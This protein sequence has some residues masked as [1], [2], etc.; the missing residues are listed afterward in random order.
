[1]K[2]VTGETA[3]TTKGFRRPACGN[4]VDCCGRAAVPWSAP[5]CLENVGKAGSA[6]QGRVRVHGV[7]S[8]VTTV[9]YVVTLYNKRRFLPHLLAGLS[10]QEGAFGRQIIFVDDGSTDGTVELLKELTAGWEN[11]V[12]LHQENAGPAA[13]TNAGIAVAGGQFIKPVDGDDMLAPWA[14][15]YLLSA[16]ES[17]GCRVAYGEMARVA[18]YRPGEP[19]EQALS[20]VGQEPIRIHRE[21]GSLDDSLH[22]A[23]Y[24]LSL[25]GLLPPTKRNEDFLVAPFSA[26]SAIRLTA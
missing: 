21:Q 19:P 22:S 6:T 11:V 1:L 15:K 14:T 12:L 3:D 23:C 17:S 2:T 18:S 9:S 25:L 10:G 4:W 5:S 24:A 26:T 20:G 16:I 7:F 8:F 13:A